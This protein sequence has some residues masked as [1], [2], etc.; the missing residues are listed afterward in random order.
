V[1]GLGRGQVSNS[2]PVLTLVHNPNL[3]YLGQVFELG[4]P[5]DRLGDGKLMQTNYIHNISIK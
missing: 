4:G 5:G 1:Y 3:S 2:V